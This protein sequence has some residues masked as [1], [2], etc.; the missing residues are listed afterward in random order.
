MAVSK[1]ALKAG[2]QKPV[3]PNLENSPLA[4]MLGVPA[5]EKTIVKIQLELLDD[6]PKQHM[7][8]MCEDELAW[9][10]GSIAEMGL[11]EPIQVQLKADGRYTVLA[12]HRR[13][14]A[15]MRN[16][17]THIDAYVR[18]VDDVTADFIFH[19]TNIGGRNKLLPSEKARG[20]TAIIQDMQSKGATNGRTTAAIAEQTG[21][22]IRQIQRY[23][24]LDTLAAGLLSMVDND[25]IPFRAGVELSYLS[26]LSQAALLEAIAELNMEGVSLKQAEALHAAA[27][28]AGDMKV[29]EIKGILS[30]QK[31]K[32]PRQAVY[33]LNKE[34]IAAYLPDGSNEAE[35][36]ELIVKALQQYVRS[37]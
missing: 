20:Y 21:E 13:K 36:E 25:T 27:N 32:K 33:K 7:Y 9:L 10:T 6:N 8:S 1:N 16:R 26:F 11:Q 19:I 34:R 28:A 23:R 30:P 37:G 12:G 22:N 35:A 4:V 29:D 18:D 14:E 31:E 5:A 24:R 3:T 17:L 2:L 15:C